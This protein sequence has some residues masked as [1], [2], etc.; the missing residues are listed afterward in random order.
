MSVLYLS[1]HSKSSDKLVP[2]DG[3]WKDLLSSKEKAPPQGNSHSI[4]GWIIWGMNERSDV[5][6]SISQP[7]RDLWKLPEKVYEPSKQY[8]PNFKNILI[9][10]VT[11]NRVVGWPQIIPTHNSPNLA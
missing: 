9:E 8:L 2:S 4:T 6:E 7:L 10:V 1:S 11:E 3:R 5:R